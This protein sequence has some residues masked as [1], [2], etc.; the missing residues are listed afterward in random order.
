[1]TSDFELVLGGSGRGRARKSHGVEENE[2]NEEKNRSTSGVDKF[3]FCLER[4]KLRHRNVGSL[5]SV[6][7]LALQSLYGGNPL[8]F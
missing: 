7:L 5:V 3:C 6:S 1:M 2:I 4:V 8:K